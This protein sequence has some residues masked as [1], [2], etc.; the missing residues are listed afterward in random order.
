M[1]R[2]FFLLIIAMMSA[3]APAVSFAASERVLNEVANLPGVESTYIGPAALRFAFGV[4]KSNMTGLPDGIK[5]MTS[6]EVIECSKASS[7]VKIEDFVRK[8]LKSRNLEMIVEN[9]SEGERTRIY[10]QVPDSDAATL[11]NI[12][13]EN[14]EKDSYQLVYVEGTIDMNAIKTG[15]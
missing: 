10:G 4:A 9:N 14:K 11:S 13:I 8:L 2:T 6:V 5:N 15:K 1:K 12:L 7:I 3:L